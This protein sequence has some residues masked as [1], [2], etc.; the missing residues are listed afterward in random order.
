MHFIKHNLILLV[1]FIHLK[2]DV[3]A[4]AAHQILQSSRRVKILLLKSIGF[5]LQTRNIWIVH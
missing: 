5:M 3:L 4:E 2:L 1:K